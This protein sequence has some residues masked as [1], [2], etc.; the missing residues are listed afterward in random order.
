MSK[1][2]V[3]LSGRVAEKVNPQIEDKI[4]EVLGSSE[5]DSNLFEYIVLLVNNNHTKDFIATDLEAFF[6]KSE[7]VDF[8]EWL[9]GVLKPYEK[10][11]EARKKLDN[12]VQAESIPPLEGVLCGK[13]HLESEAI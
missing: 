9:W 5:G 2:S 10:G 1:L 8:T 3:E 6:G 12:E 11:G 13:L 7:A 4:K